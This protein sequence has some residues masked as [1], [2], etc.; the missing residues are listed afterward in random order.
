MPRWSL[1]APGLCLAALL[2]GGAW[3][4]RREILLQDR[5]DFAYDGLPLSRH[6]FGSQSGKSVELAR[7]LFQ[8]VLSERPGNARALRGLVWA[9]LFSD[10]P[11]D[12]L[13]SLD[14]LA[15]GRKPES[16]DLALRA[17]A[18]AR[19]GREAEA[20]AAYLQAKQ[21]NPEAPGIDLA[22]AWLRI[23]ARDPSVANA[24]QGWRE[25][26]A[27][28]APIAGGAARVEIFSIWFA[29]TG[30]PRALAEDLHDRAGQ[31]EERGLLDASG[32]NAVDQLYKLLTHP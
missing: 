21:I 5:L 14:R 15:E 26:S 16:L 17:A 32:F 13:T 3:F 6:E 25:L 10:Q 29:A 20:M 9:E 8:Q 27:E 23:T 11:E 28:A 4:L 2:L 1:L 24:A 18:L 7:T 12:A 22:L 31:A 30:E 19:M